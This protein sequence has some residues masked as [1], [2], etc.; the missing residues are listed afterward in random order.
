MLSGEFSKPLDKAR[1]YAPGHPAIRLLKSIK[2]SKAELKT[3]ANGE[4]YVNAQYNK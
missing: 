1:A 3:V 2:K 4:C